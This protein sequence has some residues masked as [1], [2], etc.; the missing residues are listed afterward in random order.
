M[1][2]KSCVPFKNDW[3][4]LRY[5]GRVQALGL[6]YQTGGGVAVEKEIWDYLRL[7]ETFDRGCA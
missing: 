5:A 2:A 3:G 6:L 4:L 7:L 1:E